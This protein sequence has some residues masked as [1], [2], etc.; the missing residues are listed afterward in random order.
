[1]SA[2]NFLAI[3]ILGFAIGMMAMVLFISMASK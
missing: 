2:M 1:L 3:F